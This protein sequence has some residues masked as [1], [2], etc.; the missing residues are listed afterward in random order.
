MKQLIRGTEINRALK[1]QYRQYLCGHLKKP[2]PFLE[3]IE[4]DIEVGISHYQDFQAD[5]PHVHPVCV[6]HTYVLEGCVRFRLLDGSGEM[7]ELRQ[8]DFFILPSNTPYATKNAA[9]T[10]VLFIKAPGI[11][12]KQLIEVDQETEKW[13]SAWDQ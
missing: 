1:K 2:Q 10:R 6:E 5:Q 3:Y 13:L 11:N 12:D 8:G 9:G 4:D 7:F